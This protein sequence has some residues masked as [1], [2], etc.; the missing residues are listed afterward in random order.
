LGISDMVRGENLKSAAGKQG[1]IP[2]F[3]TN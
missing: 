3:P 2:E 1:L